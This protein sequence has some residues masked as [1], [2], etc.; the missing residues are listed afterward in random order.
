MLGL[1]CRAQVTLQNAICA[2]KHVNIY[3]LRRTGENA[4]P[5]KECGDT[6]H[7][8]AIHYIEWDVKPYIVGL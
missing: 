1:Q 2:I 8:F 7:W 4:S 5:L 3:I 6:F